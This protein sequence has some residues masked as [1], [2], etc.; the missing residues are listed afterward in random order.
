MENKQNNLTI[1]NQS[2]KFP[3]TISEK[4]EKDQFLLMY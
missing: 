3:L 4:L 2:E 1:V